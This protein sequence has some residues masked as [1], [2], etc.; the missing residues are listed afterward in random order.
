MNMLDISQ[1]LFCRAQNIRRTEAY[2][3]LLA[4]Y[5]LT[6][7]AVEMR[8][9]RLLDKCINELLLYPDG[10]PHPRYNF[11]SYRAGGNAL[12]WLLW[13][14]KS[15]Q[16]QLPDDFRARG[17][18]VLREY[19]EKTLKAPAD[20]DGI[21][22][23]PKAPEK[24]MVWIDVITAVT[25]FMVYAGLVLECEKY[26][27]FGAEQCFKMLDLFHNPENDLFHQSRGFMSDLN[28]ISH[29]HW[30]R[31][32]AWGYVGLTDM[33][34]DLP[35]DSPYRERA[36]FEFVRLSEALLKVQGTDGMW[37]QELT[38]DSCWTESS[39]SALFLY[40]FGAGLRTGLL[41]EKFKAPFLRGLNALT[42]DY[43]TDKFKTISS[44]PGCLCPGEGEMKGTI[45]AYINCKQPEDDEAHSYGAFML[46]LVE[47]HRCGIV[48]TE[49]LKEQLK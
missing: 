48:S 14:D 7:T 6:Q 39:G 34:R 13:A 3:G 20:K 44:C 15:G 32:N 16:V 29:D 40:G 24:S 4:L 46:A 38:V 41:G 12:A 37:R 35:K 10:M 28:A 21:L 11:E 47:A 23:H 30:S 1:N 18:K 2:Q 22:C 36:E 49:M 25:P 26:I 27:T 17:H 42:S 5:G 9:K 31:G 45:E 8:S 19:A 33:I 43:I